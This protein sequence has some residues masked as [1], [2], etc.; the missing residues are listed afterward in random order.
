MGSY[1]WLASLI[2]FAL[3]ASAIW[4]WEPRKELARTSSS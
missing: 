4:F 2:A 3:S 1:L